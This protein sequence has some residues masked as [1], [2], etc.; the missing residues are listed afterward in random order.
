VRESLVIGLAAVSAAAAGCGEQERR[1]SG[2]P[3]PGHAKEVARN[4]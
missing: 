3:E 2:T 4:P 1:V